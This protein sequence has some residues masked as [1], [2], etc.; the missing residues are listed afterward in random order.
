MENTIVSPDQPIIRITVPWLV[1]LSFVWS[2]ICFSLLPSNLYVANPPRI[3][4]VSMVGRWFESRRGGFFSIYLILPA[5]LWPWVDSASNRN[6]YQEP[7][8]PAHKSDN[9]TAICDS[10]VYRK[11]GSLDVSQLYGSSRLVTGISLTFYHP[12]VRVREVGIFF[13]SDTELSRSFMHM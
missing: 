8:W 2:H 13:V 6:E 10:I 12:R 9:L 7:S 3:S 11:F 4:I 5:A 1:A